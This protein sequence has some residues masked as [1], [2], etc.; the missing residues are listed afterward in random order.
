MAGGFATTWR[1]RGDAITTNGG[2][3]CKASRPPMGTV[4]TWVLWHVGDEPTTI[5][6]VWTEGGFGRLLL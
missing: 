5:V 2:R 6:A 4:P 3:F 1:G